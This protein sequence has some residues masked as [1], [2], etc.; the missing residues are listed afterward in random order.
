MHLLGQDGVVSQQGRLFDLIS[1]KRNSPLVLVTFDI[2]AP[3]SVYA[4]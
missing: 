1:M 2:I 3:N 4:I